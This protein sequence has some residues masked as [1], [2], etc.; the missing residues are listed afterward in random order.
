MATK[1]LSMPGLGTRCHLGWR[2]QLLFVEHLW[3]FPVKL[4]GYPPA[5]SCGKNEKIIEQNRGISLC[6]IEM[7]GFRSENMTISLG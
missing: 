3:S 6:G 2:Y 4:V 5:I 7:D 1:R